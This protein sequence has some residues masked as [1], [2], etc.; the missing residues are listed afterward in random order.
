MDLGGSIE[1][2]LTKEEKR[3]V[4]TLN[5]IADEAPIAESCIGTAMNVSAA[6]VKYNLFGVV[7]CFREAMRV[8]AEGSRLNTTFHDVWC[9]EYNGKVW[10]VDPDSPDKVYRVE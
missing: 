9:Y 4:R 7:R 8:N 10:A 2:Q 5:K 6:A 3:L 1:D